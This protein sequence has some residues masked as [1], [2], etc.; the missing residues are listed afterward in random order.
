MSE[1]VDLAEFLGGYIAESEQLVGSATTWLLEIEQALA[2]G[3][4]NPQ[5][6]RDLFRALHT[7]KGLAGMMGIQPI[8]DISHAFETVLRAADNAG[9]RL[10]KRAVELGLV[11][12]REIATRVRC[13]AEQ[14]AVPHAP[15]GILD[16]LAR[17]D[18]SDSAAPVTPVVL[19]WERKLSP[20]ER[21][22]LGAALAAGKLGYTISFAPSDEN[23]AR[24][25]TITSVRTA[26]G[27]IA[28][29]V[30]V[31]P[32]TES[33]APAGLVFELLVTS[34]R[35]AADIAETIGIPADRIVPVLTEA[36]A[37]AALPELRA[38][39]VLSPIG[40]SVV[41]VE[42]SR[43][44]DLQDQLA[45]LVV[46]RFRLERQLAALASSGMDVRALREIIDTQNRQL[47][48]MRRSILRVRMVRLAESLEPLTLL[49]RSLNKP[50]VKE[51]KLELDVQ[52]SELD[53]AVADR[54]L[55]ALVHL[56]RNAYDHAIEPVAERDAA[57]KP[58]AGVVRITSREGNG[59]QLV[60]SISDDGR[61]VDRAALAKRAGHAIEDD[62][63][64]LDAMTTPGLSTREVA[65]ETSGRGLGMDIVRRI[66]VSDLGGELTM[67]TEPGRGTTF[68]LDVPLTIAIIDVFSF[69]CGKQAFVVPVGSVEEIIELAEQR[70]V[71]SPTSSRGRIPLTLFERRGRTLPVVSLGTLLRIDSGATASKAL[72]VRRGAEPVAFT[73]D[74]MLGRHEVV[75]RPIEDEL[76]RVTGIAG[77]TDLGDGK[78][79]LV[80]DL[81]ELGAA[82][83]SWR[84]E[85]S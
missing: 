54:L 28:N 24:G 5:R 32:R 31:A 70:A 80:L 21:Q 59:N 57:G 23:T 56:V 61:G 53:K 79:T 38:D 11:A 83:A 14:R 29:I 27:G 43:L 41:R 22:Q 48:E 18:L 25:I 3:S 49:A 1:T 67:T 44:D 50:G 63:A 45:S 30:K 47:K 33:S 85:V 46:T 12:V 75:V 76:A 26:V 74:R 78:P 16:E 35:S 69:E 55:P 71:A 77:A 36:P 19:A 73:V 4:T 9:G 66:V 68:T 51:L 15:E 65:T 7:L 2:A 37:P 39:D 62:Q 17:V 40:R 84:A 58:R 6:V 34:E 20:G 82:V 64:A 81:V 72:V 52:A 8:V 10:G 13:V 60:L 42:L